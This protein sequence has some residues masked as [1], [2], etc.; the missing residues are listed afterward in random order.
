MRQPRTEAGSSGE[1]ATATGAPPPYE[2]E[3]RLTCEPIPAYWDGTQLRCI[4]LQLA[5]LDGPVLAAAHLEAYAGRLL[6]RSLEVLVVRDREDKVVEV[7]PSSGWRPGIAQR[8]LSGELTLC[9]LQI[10][11][12]T[13]G[14]P[15][16]RGADPPPRHGHV[17]SGFSRLK[18]GKHAHRG[19]CSHMEDE[20]IVHVPPASDCAFACLYDGHGGAE[21]A[22][23][24]KERLHFNVMASEHFAYGD[25]RA[26]LLEGFRKTE[27]DLLNEQRMES[28]ADRDSL[29][30]SSRDS[31]RDV[32]IPSGGDGR[33][34]SAGDRESNRGANRDSSSQ[35]G[36]DRQGGGDVEVADDADHTSGVVTRR[37]GVQSEVPLSGS[38]CGSTALVLLLRANE[39]HVAWL[40]DCRAVLSHA[41]VASALTADHSLAVQSE[42]MR[43][44]RE[45][46]RIE[47]GRLWGFLEVARALG[48]LDITTGE[49]PP[50]LSGQPEYVL[51]RIHREDEFI[52]LG[53]DGLWNVVAPE[54]AVRIAREELR[55]YG[56][57][58]MASEKLV[59]VALK[60]HADDNVTVMLVCL[61]PIPQPE[62]Q[63]GRPLPPWKRTQPKS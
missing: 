48:D 50:G 61:N 4:N 20:S 39:M 37:I 29:R 23:F 52:I 9:C 59:E 10:K 41:G 60:R 36:G 40:G 1:A 24:C 21:A 42:R 38:C 12:G 8:V 32:S 7:G 13:A 18:W 56:D 58:G 57:A 11:N 55:A 33:K 51:R 22:Q 6:R 62:G 19:G 47:A 63:R 5:P 49:K 53:S 30:D 31:S 2:I 45:G 28:A 15:G 27:A 3:H 26:A 54:D 46:G 25:S 35:G 43:V 14:H 34:E 16:G 44:V 17:R